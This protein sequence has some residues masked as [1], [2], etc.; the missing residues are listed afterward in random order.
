[1]FSAGPGFTAKTSTM[2]WGPVSD[3][4]L[5][6]DTD[7]LNNLDWKSPTTRLQVWNPRILSPSL[8]KTVLVSTA[9]TCKSMPIAI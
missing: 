4:R 9:T 5:D 7:S 6:L 1:M 3:S 2:L 8:R